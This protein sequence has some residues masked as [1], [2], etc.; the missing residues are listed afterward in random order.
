MPHE[1]ITGLHIHGFRTLIYFSRRWQPQ[2]CESSAFWHFCDR[3]CEL[4]MNWRV[5]NRCMLVLVLQ[6]FRSWNII[7]ECCLGF[8]PI[9]YWSVPL[10]TAWAWEQAIH[11]ITSSRCTLM[12]IIWWIQ[13]KLLVLINVSTYLDLFWHFQWAVFIFLCVIRLSELV[14]M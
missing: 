8:P 10:K 12:W 3:H 13:A 5:A 7:P 14:L 11:H 6:Y 4:W 9:H 2:G 1:F